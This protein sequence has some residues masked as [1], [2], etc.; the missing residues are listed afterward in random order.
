[1][2][3]LCCHL[4]TG[5]DASGVS[6]APAAQRLVAPFLK[7]TGEVHGW[8]KNRSEYLVTWWLCHQPEALGDTTTLPAY[9]PSYP[10]SLGNEHGQS[11]SGEDVKL[12]KCFVGPSMW[13]QPGAGRNVWSLL[14]SPMQV[15]TLLG[16][17]R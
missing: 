3:N 14:H 11:R 17:C 9:Q 5:M 13:S 16:S 10:T 6:P 4:S 2:P 1:M 12:L 15:E 8:D 7:V